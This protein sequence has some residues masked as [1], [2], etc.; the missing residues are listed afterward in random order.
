MS[1][2]FIPGVLAG[3]VLWASLAVVVASLLFGQGC[4]VRSAGIFCILL[5]LRLLLP[6]PAPWGAF[7]ASPLWAVLIGVWLTG[8]LAFF[9]V[10]SL[11]TMANYRAAILNEEA[12]PEKLSEEF[13]A[14]R[15]RLGIRGRPVLLVTRGRLSPMLIGIVRPLVVIPD[16]WAKREGAALRC[17]LYHELTHFKRGD[18][19]MG[20][21][22]TLAGALHWFNRFLPGVAKRSRLWVEARCDGEVCR[23]LP[24]ARPEAVYAQTLLEFADFPA[25][26]E[27]AA[28]LAE[29]EHELAW[30]VSRLLEPA[31]PRRSRNLRCVAAFLVLSLS[32]V[33]WPSA[34]AAPDAAWKP[35]PYPA[36]SGWRYLA[37]QAAG[38]ELETLRSRCGDGLTGVERQ[39]LRG[40]QDG[41]GAV[42][43][44]YS[45]R[46]PQEAEQFWQRS[47]PFS[48]ALCLPHGNDVYEIESV[49][50]DVLIPLW[51]E[52]IP[53]S[54]IEAV[55]KLGA[56]GIG[57]VKVNNMLEPFRSEVAARLG[58][59]VKLLYNTYLAEGNAQLNFIEAGEKDSALKL[60]TALLKFGV[61]PENAVVLSPKLAVEFVPRALPPEKAAEIR[62]VLEKYAAVPP[63]KVK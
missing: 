50:M 38:T 55:A 36:L 4:G 58:C 49:H 30:R 34:E 48:R 11:R 62:R 6:V 39:E 42:V 59:G 17:L 43:V 18:L 5:P 10:S 41:K 25:A 22:W 8:A 28:S 45:F 46:T 32:L 19:L 61:L 24:D 57:F 9:L 31:V 47:Y 40:P 13:V 20:W 1:G 14:A 2:W 26:S 60:R 27:G 35:V 63:E 54:I 37:L 7:P 23:A 44:R 53:D 12:V 29:G 52:L 51:A 56:E 21:L 3:S 33:P 16:G 15:R